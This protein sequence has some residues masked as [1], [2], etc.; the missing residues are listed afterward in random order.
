MRIIPSSKLTQRRLFLGSLALLGALTFLI[1]CFPSKH[2]STE[3][4]MTVPIEKTSSSYRNRSIVRSTQ[5]EMARE[6]QPSIEGNVY[7][8]DGVPVADASVVATT[9]ELAGNVTSAAGGMKSDARGHF[10]IPLPRGTY[11][12]R[13]NHDGYGPATVTAK[14]GETVSVMLPKSGVIEGH[15][16]DE[17]GQPVRQ[18]AIDVIVAVPADIPATPPVWSKRFDSPDGSFRVDALPVWD[19]VIRATAEGYAP[20]FTEQIGLEPK[21]TATMELTLS[22]GCALTGKV[23]DKS[24]KALPHVYVDAE[25]RLAAGE[26]SDLSMHAAAQAESDLDGSFHLENVPKGTVL[27]RGYDGS[28]AV[29]TVTVDVSDC[30]KAAPVELAMSS[31]GGVTGVA[32]NQEGRPLSGAIVSLMSRALGYVSTTTDGEGRY[33]FDDLAPGIVRVELNYHGNSLLTFTKITDGEVSEHDLVLYGGGKGELRG[34]VTASGKPIA[35]ARLMIAANRGD[36]HEISVY[37]PV[38][39]ADGNY[40]VSSLPPGAYLINVLTVARG[41]GVE[42]KADEVA[43]ADID[44]TPVPRREPPPEHRNVAPEAKPTNG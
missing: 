32:R 19:V 26:M 7:G 10:K 28:N 43:N 33:S 20:A 11:Q 6:A 40:S 41:K 36:G 12:L 15:V 35:G 42:V 3:G 18:F 13:V 44:V 31:G 17:K 37:N 29:S 5:G 14:S 39:D 23:V 22:R 25:S 16:R 24:G 34:R 9:F 21:G 2:R 4:A 30:D 27:V 38:T 1:L 8:M